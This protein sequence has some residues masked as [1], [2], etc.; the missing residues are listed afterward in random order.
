MASNTMSKVASRLRQEL[1]INSYLNSG[2]DVHALMGMRVIRM[3]AYGSTTL[4]L[5]SFLSDLGHSGAEIGLFMTLT[6]IG[7]VIISLL[8]TLFADRLGRRRILLLGSLLMAASGLVFWR[9]TNYWLLLLAAIFGVISPSGNEIGP[10]RAV[11]ESTIA[12]LTT[13]QTRTDI[14][15]L[16]V[17]GGTLGTSAG[18]LVSGFLTQELQS[19]GF[20]TTASYQVIFAMYAMLG[21]VKALWSLRLSEDCEVVE[22]REPE[23]SH[24]ALLNGNPPEPAKKTMFQRSPASQQTVLKLCA[25]FF[26]DSLARCVRVLPFN[27]LLMV[28]SGM[29]PASLIAF[30]IER[31]FLISFAWLGTIIGVC[32]LLSSF[33]N[34]LASSVAR[35]IGLIQ[36]MVFTHLPSAIF[37]AL[38]PAPTTLWLTV[39]FLVGRSSLSAMDQAPRSAFLAAV[40]LPEERT[41][42]MGIVNIVKTVGQSAGPTI[43]GILAAGGHFWIAFVIAGALKASYDLAM[44]RMFASHPVAQARA[45]FTQADELDHV[46]AHD[47]EIV[48][49]R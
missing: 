38:I 20:G 1:G 45:T 44:L 9:I 8:L 6:L 29:V 5:A 18:S 10:F 42:V 32:Q 33:G 4:I 24:A 17:V 36:T 14:F 27:E 43:T 12:H 31:K 34:I 22:S 39:V 13:E 48:P 2:P 25:L 21:F 41:A 28:G 3:F 19:L 16:Y 35:R 26:F 15:A 46:S 49:A 47:T 37:L 11:E 40:V 7:D 30:F 23:E